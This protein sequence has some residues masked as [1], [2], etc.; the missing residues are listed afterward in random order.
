M[1]VVT[2]KIR[3]YLFLMQVGRR[4][5]D[6][7]S[8]ADVEIDGANTDDRAWET[9]D[10]EAEQDGGEYRLLDRSH[11]WFS[12]IVSSLLFTLVRAYA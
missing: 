8:K 10:R 1:A 2:K 5:G 6:W 7:K 11:A 12:V 9:S 4:S 3:P